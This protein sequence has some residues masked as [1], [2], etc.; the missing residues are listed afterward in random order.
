MLVAAK[1]LPSFLTRCVG[2]QHTLPVRQYSLQE[3]RFF[4]T[5]GQGNPGGLVRRLREQLF[6][7]RKHMRTAFR[8]QHARA[9][10][11]DKLC[12]G[13]KES[14]HNRIDTKVLR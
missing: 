14:V 6:T 13:S 4:R 11:R 1:A 2:Q 5:K 12:Q 8:Y 9:G 3:W 7:E 10:V